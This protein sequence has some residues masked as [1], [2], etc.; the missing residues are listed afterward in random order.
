MNDNYYA[1]EVVENF[2]KK[3]IY[4]G[5]KKFEHAYD[6]GDVTAYRSL[7]KKF[8]SQRDVQHIVYVIITDS[9]RDVVRTRLLPELSRFLKPYG[10]FIMSGGE[11]FNT[12]VGQD[13]RLVTS[14]IDTKFIPLFETKDFF[15]DLQILKIIFWDKLNLILKKYE[16][17]F[18]TIINKRIKEFK[19]STL[20]GLSIPSTGVLLKRRYTLMMKTRTDHSTD[21]VSPGNTLIDVELFAIDMNVRYFNVE[22]GKVDKMNL[23]GVLDIAFMRPGEFG[24]D[25]ATD[26]TTDSASV[27]VAGK[28]FFLEDLYFMQK[29]GLRPNKRIKD[30]ERMVSFAKHVI[31]LKNTSFNFETLYKL[32]KKKLNTKQSKIR[33]ISFQYEKELK[34][35]LAIDPLKDSKRIEKPSLKKI[36]A[37]AYGIKGP[38]GLTIDKYNPTNSSYKVDIEKGRWL[39]NSRVN[40]IR[41][42]YNYRLNQNANVKINNKNVPMPLY[43]YKTRR[44]HTI[45]RNIVDKSVAIQF[46]RR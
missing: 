17:I 40:Y 13:A 4:F 31:G 36:Q 45:P 37:M 12:F 34:R 5:E 16:N 8:V 15:R 30:K 26:F 43:G 3:Y 29:L 23:G 28:G 10:E 19:I 41:N 44:N 25:I 7:L 33:K 2:K 24:S 1:P 21:K 42:E 11:V 22:S 20:L 6:S 38:I 9:V 18:R 39:Q 14:D 35:A 46:G 32:C 27:Q